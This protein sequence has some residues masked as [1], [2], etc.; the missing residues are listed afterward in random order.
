MLN[1]SVD[2]G[3][4]SLNLVEFVFRSG[5]YG[6]KSGVQRDGLSDRVPFLCAP[7]L[8]CPLLMWLSP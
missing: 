7:C 4:L 6:V 5:K 2:S 3:G 8:L 1:D